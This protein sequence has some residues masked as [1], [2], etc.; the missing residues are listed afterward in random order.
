[1]EIYLL[2]ERCARKFVSRL[3]S[4][5][6]SVLLAA[7]LLLMALATSSAQAQDKSKPASSGAQADAPDGEPSSPLQKNSSR[8]VANKLPAAHEN[9]E[10]GE[11]N[12][13]LKG[14]K[15]SAESL[16]KREEWFYK[17]RAS[18]NGHIPAG[19]RMRALQHMQNMMV[20]E[21]KLVQR[22][23][24]S[25]SAA[26]P[27]IVPQSLSTIMWGPSGPA[28][29]TGG[30]FSPVTGRITAIAVDPSDT[31]G[32]TVLI[33]GAQGGIWR[34][35]NAGVNWT[36]V[37]DQNASLAMGSI[38]FAPS[39]CPSGSTTCTVYAGTGEQAGIGFDIY[40][41][42]GV[43]KSTN[44]G[45]TWA[46]TCSPGPSCPFVGPFSDITPFG[47]FTLGG[48]RISY[49][50][51][52]PAN[53]S[54]VLAAAQEALEGPAEGVYCSDTGGASWSNILPGEMATFVGFGSST[55]AYAALGNTF[56]SSP[57]GTQG[58]AN[59]NGIYKATNIGSTCASITFSRL[60]AAT[61][62]V[63]SSM[64]RIDIGIAP[65]DATGNTLYA[66]IANATNGG[67]SL[68]NLGVFVT[69]SGGTTWTQTGA[70]DICQAQCWYDNVVKVDPINNDIVF[71]GGSAVLNSAGTAANWVMRSLNGTTGGVFSSAIAVTSGGGLPHVD[72]HAMAFASTAGG[73]RMYLGNDGGIWRT[74]SAEASTINWINLN[75]APLQLTQFYPSISINPANPNIAFDGAQ[76]N[77]SQ[78]YQGGVAWIDNGQCGDGASTAVDQQIPSTVYIGCGTGAQV[79][80]SYQ[81]GGL[82]T[83][84]P[85]IS[86]INQAD[87]FGFIPPLTVDE[88]TANT[89][90]FGT[91]KVY[92]STD[93]GLNW[94]P[95]SS[96]LPTT[97][98]QNYLTAIAA[99]PGN[100]TNPGA[101][102][103]AGADT[104]QVF[105]A[106]NVASGT[107]TFSAVTGQGLLPSRFVTAIAVDP[108]DA[109]GKTAYVAMSGFAFNTDTKGHIFKT[110]D[111]GATF[112]DVSCAPTSNCISPAA[113]DLPNTP[114]NDIV[115]DPDAPGTIFAATDIGVFF[116]TSCTVAPCTWATLGTG[117]PHVA[118]LSLRLHEAS[119]TL[120]A[121][122]HGRGA[123]DVTLDNVTF[124]GPRISSISPVSA[125]AGGTSNVPLT[126]NGSGL[127]GG[128]VK[129]GSTSLTTTFVSDSQL[130]AT[131]TPASLTTA[132]TPVVTVTTTTA[133]SNNVTF[134]ILGGAPTITN[135]TPGSAA[136][137]AATATLTITGT[138]FTANSK[139][140]LNPDFVAT[141]LTTTFGSAT[142]LTAM[143]PA[144]F[145]A[146]FGSTNSVGVSTPPPGGGTT[147]T[148]ST[149]PLP[150][151]VVSA[152]APAN[153]NFASATVISGNSS[154]IIEDSSAATV[155]TGDPILSCIQQITG[156]NGSFSSVWFKFTP[157]STGLLTDVDT[158]GSSYDTTLGIFTGSALGSL[159]QVP[160]ACNDDINPGIDTQSQIQNIVLSG[161]TTYY[162]FAGAFGPPDPNPVALGGKLVLNFAFNP[163]AAIPDFTMTPQAPTTDTVSSG[164][165]ATYTVAIGAVNGFTANVSLSCSL[166]A[167]STTCAAN[168][169]S[170]AP[171]SNTTITV[172]TM[173]H[174]MLPPMQSPRRLGPW[175]KFLPI[176]V[177]AL[178]AAMLLA[179][180]ARTRR[181]RLAA[182]IPVAGMILFL[183][184]Q[185]VGCGGGGGGNVH[186]TQAGTYTVTITG[187]SGSTTHTATVT[188]VV[189]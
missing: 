78:N 114:V 54:L 44:N 82:G 92:Q 118:V 25:F 175:L 70:P 15:D 20:R 6:C 52:S 1:M 68:T 129:L 73:V 126:V 22:P 49:I 26:A 163:N 12:G 77:G 102:V 165:N 33:G 46:P 112:T 151:F 56:G 143:V 137:N 72:Q 89:L 146:G 99:L 133:T 164:G 111:G 122:T 116:A 86:G 50:A 90:Y 182:A 28:P 47:F 181:Q 162:I 157:T 45:V 5:L 60:T 75:T 63:Q 11:G 152:A 94:T 155:Q 110:I 188:L 124:T 109:T 81:N 171:G 85:A 108:T 125:A 21:G 161:G 10:A 107:G 14:E 138:N 66:S 131:I 135:S 88:G 101:V 176:T 74:D 71:L 29:T 119:R 59:G 93:A 172:T 84:A 103:Y 130:I 144:S 41:G 179:F 100:G 35:T 141:P 55:V 178:L 187:N 166:T 189:N 105:V 31:S 153:D 120:R 127:T 18:V 87:T 177:L 106:T 16:R 83:F 174:Q 9:E 140:V 139:V 156:Q 95:I 38:A 145:M 147:H 3:S 168:P 58:N 183:V 158:I 148:T 185:A 97:G 4:L 19:A 96:D 123:F 67:S 53:A 173:A 186:G 76:D 23:D 64:G 36:A 79:N 149:A 69:T 184:L 65:K 180:V 2:S 134:S 159:T 136:V 104:G 30:T 91:T 169:A 61:L 121:A 115:L 51:V 40:Y 24:G 154:Q 62:P 160:G 42:A 167:A 57:V 80:A 39:T 7:A 8:P 27:Q 32:S 142:Q 128:T 34:S 13:L 48:M 170:V 43:L 132:G 17:Q 113:S 37:G 150:T 117:L 98:V